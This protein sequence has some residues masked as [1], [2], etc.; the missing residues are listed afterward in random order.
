[1]DVAAAPKLKPDDGG[2]A[3][4]ADAAIEISGVSLRFDTADG[5]VEALSNVNLKVARG[6]FVSF[7]GPSGCGKTTLLRAVADLETP[8]SGA[9]RVN[10][11]SPHEARAS[12][13]YGYVFQAPALY[14][15][16]SVARNIALPLEVMGF[17]KAE[18][19]ARVAKGL[20]LVNLS[21]FGA[22]YP[23]QLSGGMQQRASIARALSF[24]PD[25]LLMDEPFG[26][27]DE[28]VRDM[29]NQQLLRLWDVTGKT[30][31]FVTH[32][33]PE[34]V[35]LSTHIVVMSPRPGRI[36]DVIACDLPRDRALDI[37]ETPEFLAIANRVRHGLREGHS[38]DG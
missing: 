10:G 29:L 33:I 4:A 12:R 34:A 35:F 37:R 6:E 3:P 32:S 26:A 7:I 14:P 5:P 8:T 23:W 16:R 21:G 18:R 38:Y 27:L 9:I 1:M 25:L 17:A 20:E 15:W 36:I 2:K 11:M 28:I 30:V 31:M 22:K 19:E 13:A 24:D